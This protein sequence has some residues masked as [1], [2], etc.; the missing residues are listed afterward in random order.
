MKH[1]VQIKISQYGESNF[2]EIEIQCH[3]KVKE[4]LR[5]DIYDF[6]EMIS[7]L[8]KFRYSAS[9]VRF[10]QAS[11]NGFQGINERVRLLKFIRL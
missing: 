4:N 3:R 6:C 7:N 1:T 11:I 10:A 8:E 9:T 5:K 2:S